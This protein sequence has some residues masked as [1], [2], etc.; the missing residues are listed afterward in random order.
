[1]CLWVTIPRRRPAFLSLICH[2]ELPGE[3]PRA[4][5][6][7][8]KEKGTQIT[9][10]RPHIDSW[11]PSSSEQRC[12]IK[13]ERACKSALAVQVP[14]SWLQLSLLFC[15][16]GSWSNPL[17][18][19]VSRDTCWGGGFSDGGPLAV[20]LGGLGQIPLLPHLGASSCCCPLF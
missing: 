7:S 17:A 18:L 5:E 15:E 11:V 8:V 3:G 4:Q 12:F 10:E 1:M 9:G 6:K 14:V 13:L 16:A 19:N 20:W 2:M